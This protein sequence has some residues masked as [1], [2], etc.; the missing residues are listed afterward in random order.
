MPT[1]QF[2]ITDYNYKEKIPIRFLKIIGVSFCLKVSRS[3]YN[4]VIH[5]SKVGRQ[6]QR[7]YAG[8]RTMPRL[9]MWKGESAKQIGLGAK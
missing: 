5:E 4:S 1:L 6:T 8:R 2:I 9:K 7:C 3:N